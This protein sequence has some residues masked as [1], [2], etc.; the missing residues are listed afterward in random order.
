MRFLVLGAGGV[1]GYFGARLAS[2]GADVTFLVRQARQAALARDGL[3]VLSPLGDMRVQPAT[4][5]SNEIARGTGFD[6]VILACKA[7]DLDSAMEAV[8]PAVEASTLVLPLLNGL[9]HL[10]ALDA[11]FDAARVMGGLCHIGVTLD[12]SGAVRHLNRLQH[13]AFGPRSPDQEERCTLLH[14]VLARGGF[15]SI[16]SADIVQDMWEKFVLLATY[17][18][19]TCLMRGPVGAIVSSDE[20]A[21]IATE[22]LSECA[23]IA[24]GAGHP[25]GQVFLAETL[26]MLT[27]PGSGATAS[28]LRDVQNGARTEHAHVLGDML[29]RGG[30]ARYPLLRVANAHLQVYEATRAKA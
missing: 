14:A 13:F 19:T 3:V 12:P 30:G 16:L 6:V 5:A 22:M 29:R 26:A 18:G 23:A 27:E 1:G 4:V 15:S 2:A 24:A 10:E 20:G 11:R 9:R 7:Y 25:P 8:A 17:A 21:A 28:M